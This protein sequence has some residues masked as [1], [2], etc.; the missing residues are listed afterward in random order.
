MAGELK[1]GRDP[2]NDVLLKGALVS[3]FHARLNL[4]TQGLWLTDV[5]THGTFVGGEKLLLNQP[6]R[7]KPGDSF[8]IGPYKL[9]Y[10]AAETHPLAVPAEPAPVEPA[11]VEPVSTEP[12]PAEPALTAEPTPAEPALTAEPAPAEPTSLN[13]KETP[14]LPSRDQPSRYQA[15]LPMIFHEDY[16]D[17]QNDFLR[18]YLLLF[19]AIWERLE[20]RQD[21]IE[22]YFDPQA[23]PETFIDWLASWFGLTINPDWPEQQR[24]QILD[25]IFSL[26]HLRGTNQ[27]LTQIIE[28]CIGLTPEIVAEKTPFVFRIK[29]RVPPG[30]PLDK[31][32]LKYLIETHKPAHAAYILDLPL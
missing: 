8:V 18:R 32:L 30:Y 10:I 14:L 2:R 16:R 12:A 28:Q 15:L 1:I 13:E 9:T 7:I 4:D 21:Y 6:Y 11:P 5:S 23:C 25:K 26:Y 22:L 29:L 19:E 20:Q 17:K 3:R 27:G 31:S 24:R